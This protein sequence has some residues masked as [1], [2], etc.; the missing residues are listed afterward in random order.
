[1]TFEIQHYTW[2]DGWVNASTTQN[3]KGEVVPLTYDTEAE[4]QA[5]L[6]GYMSEI[7]SQIATGEREPDHGYSK[8]EFRIVPSEG[9]A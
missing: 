6:D 4:A 9:S 2:L 8:D 3:G 5:E 1:M 7:D